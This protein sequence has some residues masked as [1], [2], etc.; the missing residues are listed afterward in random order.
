MKDPT[1]LYF[2]LKEPWFSMEKNKVKLHEYREINVYY[3][4]RFVKNEE[5]KRRA[6]AELESTGNLSDATE[7][8]VEFCAKEYFRQ[9]KKYHGALGM[10]SQE[11]HPER[12]FEFGKPDIKIGIG[13]VN[14]GAKPGKKYFVITWERK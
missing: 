10:C 9:F 13:S 12:H 2:T 4:R 7:A 5:V 14:W 1:V 6:I 8:L 11:K 3:I